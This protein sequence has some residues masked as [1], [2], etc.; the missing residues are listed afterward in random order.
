MHAKA[1]KGNRKRNTV[2]L[3]S[4]PC[5]RAASSGAANGP[6]GTHARVAAEASTG[7]QPSSH[8]AIWFREGREISVPTYAFSTFQNI[9]T[10]AFTIPRRLSRHAD[11]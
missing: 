11:G 4:G 2:S 7:R 6:A 5:R 10:F 9:G 8:G 3:G 1:V